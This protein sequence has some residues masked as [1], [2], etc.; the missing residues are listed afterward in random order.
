MKRPIVI[1]FQITSKLLVGQVGQN[2]KV[3]LDD[4]TDVGLNDL[5]HPGVGLDEDY[6]PF[7]SKAN[8]EINERPKL[9]ET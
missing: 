7:G 8:L 6:S 2:D 4:E 5:R 9:D 1:T 3:E